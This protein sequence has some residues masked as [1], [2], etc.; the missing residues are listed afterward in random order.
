M[1]GRSL[2]NLFKVLGLC[3]GTTEMEIKVQ[4]KALSRIYHP[5]RHDPAHAGLTHKAAAYFFK[6][7]NNAQAYLQEVL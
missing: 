3:L 7:I 5:D 1:V 2:S 6:L 4:Y